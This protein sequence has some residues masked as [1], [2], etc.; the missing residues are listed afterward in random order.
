[1]KRIVIALLMI[2]G[3]GPFAV[4]DDV[5]RIAVLDQLQAQFS[6]CAAF[7]MIELRCNEGRESRRRLAVVSRRTEALA[8]AVSMSKEA[9]ALRLELNVAASGALR[10]QKHRDLGKPVRG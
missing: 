7:Y 1:M 10:L 3:F 5:E 8:T 2:I 9:A 4:A 6:V